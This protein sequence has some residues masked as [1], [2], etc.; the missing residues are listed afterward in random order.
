MNEKKLSAKGLTYKSIAGSQGFFLPVQYDQSRMEG[1][2]V[3]G[4]KYDLEIRECEV[5]GNG[6]EQEKS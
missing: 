1:G 2:L 3:F 5:E 6:S 4:K